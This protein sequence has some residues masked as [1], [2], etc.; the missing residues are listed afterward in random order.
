MEKTL[1]KEKRKLARWRTSYFFRQG[2][3][4]EQN[5]FEVVN[6]KTNESIGHLIDLTLEGMKT[7]GPTAVNRDETYHFRINLPKEVKGVQKITVEAQCVWSEKDINPE[8]YSAGYKIIYISPPF[9]EII[10]T[11]IN[12]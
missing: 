12:G 9:S 1:S 11:L 3:S 5:Y 10:E 8:F 7:L 6:V 4:Y 2:H